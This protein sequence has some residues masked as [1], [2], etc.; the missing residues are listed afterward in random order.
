M[1]D[2]DLVEAALIE[3]RGRL[4]KTARIIK[5]LGPSAAPGAFSALAIAEFGIRH[6]FT[7]SVIRD[8]DCCT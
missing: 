1:A 8:T 2:G 5:N 4:G 7:E 3:G 6:A